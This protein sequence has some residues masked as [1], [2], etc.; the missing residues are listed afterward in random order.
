M[1]IK[2]TQNENELILALTGSLDNNTSKQL[3]A[4]LSDSIEELTS[5]IFDFS[6]LEY[7]SSA[8]LRVLLSTQKKMQTKGKMSI[9]GANQSVMDVFVITGFADIFTFED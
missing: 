2:K 1:Q 3:E 6:G 5:L 7:I 8:G 4:E 9:R